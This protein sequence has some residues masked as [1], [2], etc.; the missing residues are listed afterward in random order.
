[1]GNQIDG[2]NWTKLKNLLSQQTEYGVG[3]RRYIKKRCGGK[4]MKCHSRAQ[5]L[6]ESNS[7]GYLKGLH[8]N[9]RKE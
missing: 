3:G 5:R 6:K 2:K 4:K 7:K 1:M 8:I 9:T